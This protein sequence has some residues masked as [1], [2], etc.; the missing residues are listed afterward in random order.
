MMSYV[1]VFYDW[2]E[3]V[4]PL[5]DAER[6]RLFCALLEY[7]K[8]GE[9]PALSGNE[10]FLFPV[11]RIQIDRDRQQYEK[12]SRKPGG[13]GRSEKQGGSK[14]PKTQKSQD[15]DKDDDK[16][17]DKE[18]DK[19]QDQDDDEDKNAIHACGEDGGAADA[20]VVVV[21]SEAFSEIH[22]SRKARE[23]PGEFARSIGEDFCPGTISAAYSPAKPPAENF[24]RGSP[25]PVLH[26]SP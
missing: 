8:T 25:S 9:I 14:T 5:D 10:R 13:Q 16:E 4:E 21:E 19:D 2:L 26:F 6:G 15:K 20:A 11:L 1:K 24:C 3:A 7:A 22:S 12:L 23:E 17:K 18:K